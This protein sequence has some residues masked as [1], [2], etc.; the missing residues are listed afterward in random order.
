MDKFCFMHVPF[1]SIVKFQFLAQFPEDHIS[2]PFMS[3]IIL[4]FSQFDAF[5]TYTHYS[6]ASYLLLL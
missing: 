2:Y 4:A 6:V 5:A 3:I 1:G